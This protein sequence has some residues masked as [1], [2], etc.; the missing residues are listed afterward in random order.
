LAS[1]FEFL[2]LIV[3][4]PGNLLSLTTSWAVYFPA[5]S[6]LSLG[7]GVL[8]FCIFALLASGYLRNDHW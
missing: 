5:L 3:L 1:G 2:V 8:G 4:L 7:F 6:R